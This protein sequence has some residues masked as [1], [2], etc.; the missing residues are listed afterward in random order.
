MNIAL[1]CATV[2]LVLGC[3]AA[4]S[5]SEIAVLYFGDSIIVR[6]ITF[7]VTLALSHATLV[8]LISKILGKQGTILNRD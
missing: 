4:S 3:I 1:T 2:G 6:A 7:A 8:L 5:L